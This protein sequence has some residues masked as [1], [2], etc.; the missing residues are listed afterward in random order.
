VVAM[1]ALERRY[2]SEAS[3]PCL[4]RIKTDHVRLEELTP[5]EL[6]AAG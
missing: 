1:V 4:R 3:R 6:R 2:G 5:D